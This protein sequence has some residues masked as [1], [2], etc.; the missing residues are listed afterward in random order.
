MGTW[1]PGANH[2]SISEA[3][4]GLGD[5]AACSRIFSGITYY[6][7]RYT[8]EIYSNHHWHPGTVAQMTDHVSLDNPHFQVT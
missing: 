6:N 7:Y 4:V 1:G 5:D 8:P 2:F 3:K